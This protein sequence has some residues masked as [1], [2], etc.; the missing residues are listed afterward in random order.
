[1]GIIS[2]WDI[3]EK[4]TRWV[5]SKLFE[6]TVITSRI[7]LAR[8]IKGYPFPHNITYEESKKIEEFL[9]N[10]FLKMPFNKVFIL[11][12]SSL[13]KKEKDFL[14]ERHLISKEFCENGICSKVI[15]IPEKKVTIMIN[16]EDHLRIQVIFPG[17]NLKRCWKIANEIDN[18]IDKM[19]E[20]AFL[21]NLGFL[22]ACPTN[23]GTG[24]RG[25]VLMHIPGIKFL[26]KDRTIFDMIRKIGIN[27]RGFYGEGSLPFGC[28]YQLSS[29]S[30]IG[31]TE[32]EIIKELESVV[33]LIKEEEKKCIEEIRKDKNLKN[34]IYKKIKEICKEKNLNG[35]LSKLYSFLLLGIATNIFKVEKRELKKILFSFLS[36]HKELDGD[37]VNYNFSE[38]KGKILKRKIWEIINV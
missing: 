34:K 12:I 24:L 29:S 15:I 17:L 38:N 8:N 14:I 16:E 13:K 26:K 22:T 11:D 21:P 35:K 25:S 1:M 30:S 2:N 27:I 28:I 4:E 3:I 10:I 32:I 33:K 20:F 9:I 5:Y 23:I 37:N 36:E 19:V 18:Y 6:N 7:R 31:K